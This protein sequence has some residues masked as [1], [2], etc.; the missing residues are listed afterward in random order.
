MKHLGNILYIIVW[1]LTISLRNFHCKTDTTKIKNLWYYIRALSIN[2]HVR[3]TW[4]F[5]RQLEAVRSQ[6]FVRIDS[7]SFLHSSYL[8]Q[9]RPTRYHRYKYTTSLLHYVLQLLHIRYRNSLLLPARN[10][11]F[12]SI[13][14]LRI[15]ACL[16][17]HTEKYWSYI[18]AAMIILRKVISREREPSTIKGFIVSHSSA[19]QRTRNCLSRIVVRVWRI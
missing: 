3:L 18:L 7:F 15:Y 9:A 14:L 13:S 5:A 16:W 11:I 6:I 10:P 12:L 8:A 2:L 4:L 17:D 19:A 1:D